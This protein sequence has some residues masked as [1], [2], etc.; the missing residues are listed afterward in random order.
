MKKLWAALLIIL[1]EI[2]TIEDPRALGRG[3]RLGLMHIG[4]L[5]FG[6]GMAFLANYLGEL[7]VDWKTLLYI[8]LFGSTSGNAALHIRTPRTQ[9]IFDQLQAKSLSGSP[10]NLSH[11]KPTDAE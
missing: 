1:E 2:S 5:G 3:V 11:D 8:S 9:E 7:G 4:I 6:I 10:L